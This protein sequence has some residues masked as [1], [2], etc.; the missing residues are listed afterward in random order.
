MT[1]THHIRRQ[2]EKKKPCAPRKFLE[3]FED[4]IFPTVAADASHPGTP[5]K[6]LQSSK[7]I[8]S[9]SA[10][11]KTLQ[12]GKMSRHVVGHKNS[13][14]AK[15]GEPSSP[16]FETQPQT[17][18]NTS[19][20][21]RRH[22]TC[23][24][25]RSSDKPSCEPKSPEKP[26][27][28]DK[29]KI[30]CRS[31]FHQ[32]LSKKSSRPLVSRTN[33]KQ[34]AAPVIKQSQ[35]PVK[36][37][38][39]GNASDDLATNGGRQTTSVPPAPIPT[40]LELAYDIV[41]GKA[42]P[43][44]K[45]NDHVGANEQNFGA[46]HIQHL[47]DG[48]QSPEDFFRPATH[49]VPETGGTIYDPVQQID[50]ATCWKNLKYKDAEEMFFIHTIFQAALKWKLT[51]DV[52][53]MIRKIK[54]DFV[55]GTGETIYRDGFKVA[56][57]NRWVYVDREELVYV[58]T[59]M[60]Y[61]FFSNRHHQPDRSALMQL[62]LSSREFFLDWP[63]GLRQKS[64][65][66]TTVGLRTCYD[67]LSQFE[68][69]V[70]M[71][72]LF[73]DYVDFPN[74]NHTPHEDE[75]IF[76]TPRYN[77]QGGYLQDLQAGDVEY[78]MENP[79]QWLTWNADV[80]GFAGRVPPYS[81][82]PESFVASKASS[83]ITHVLD[84]TIN[85]VIRKHCTIGKVH[86]ERKVRSRLQLPVLRMAVRSAMNSVYGSD[87]QHSV[88][89]SQFEH[90]QRGTSYSNDSDDA[91]DSHCGNVTRVPRTL[92]QPKRQMKT[93]HP[94]VPIGSPSADGPFDADWPRKVGHTSH[95]AHHHM[96]PTI[97]TV[98]DYQHSNPERDASQPRNDPVFEV[99]I[100]ISRDD[101]PIQVMES[102]DF[103]SQTPRAKQ[104][105]W[106]DDAR[107]IEQTL[108]SIATCF[109]PS[110]IS[111]IELVHVKNE[112]SSQDH[113]GG[114][115]E[116]HT[117]K[118]AGDGYGNSSTTLLDERPCILNTESVVNLSTEPEMLESAYI[119]HES[120]LCG[121]NDAADGRLGLEEEMAL[122]SAI[123]NSREEQLQRRMTAQGLQLS[124][125]DIFHEDASEQGFDDASTADYDASFDE[126]CAEY[127]DDQLMTERMGNKR[128]VRFHLMDE[129][130]D[131]EVL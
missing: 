106:T 108:P 101:L 91:P 71:I 60:A 93:S 82:F 47:D 100:G 76:L 51:T 40:K 43:I 5:S 57:E 58:M 124:F 20:L 72:A 26:H 64:A 87:H 24:D 13:P 6:R 95:R 116:S 74:L 68:A 130:T 37:R 7:S 44:S 107:A 1:C 113:K 102:L 70:S 97:A 29:T 10:P 98:E 36:G 89:P 22:K 15:G 19:K 103:A 30:E 109:P 32:P 35:L 112:S 18:P 86:F 25:L 2:T 131:G 75:Y 48:L 85:A 114:M 125:D 105:K 50:A 90:L 99:E 65:R 122:Q 8:S 123:V 46:L 111:P 92:T 129:G 73:R 11:P 115:T 88:V 45:V 63:Q 128:E 79:I 17:S 34:K 66:W 80:K 119:E 16:A 56:I 23:Q 110:P 53:S 31:Q 77:H 83:A 14:S 120:I 127:L 41:S 39:M 84:I 42:T 9:L 81:A 96:P 28:M 104:Q 121:E 94:L 3:L 117:Y 126:S 78:T 33:Q 38:P 61:D 62:Y 118:H 59:E 67:Q 52:Q 69:P 27:A 54:R 55:L 21:L 49:S 12:Y 4:R